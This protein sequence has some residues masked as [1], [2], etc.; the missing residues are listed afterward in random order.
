M[1]F[2]QFLCNFRSL[3]WYEESKITYL[4]LGTLMTSYLNGS[5]IRSFFQEAEEDIDAKSNCNCPG[6]PQVARTFV[7]DMTNDN[8]ELYWIDPWINKIIA[9]DMTGCKCRVIVDATEMK[10]HGFIPNSITVDSKYIYWFNSTEEEIYYTNKNQSSKI[11]HVKASYGYKIISLD[12]GNQRYPPRECLF[13]KLHNLQPKIL[14]NTDKTITLKLPSVQKADNCKRFEYEMTLTEYTILYKIKKSNDTAICDKES[15]FFVATT[16]VEVVLNDLKPF[17]NYTVMLEVTN[18]Y[19]KLHEIK[20]L[21][22]L[23]LVFQTAAEGKFYYSIIVNYLIL[24]N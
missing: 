15:C 9:T 4:G 1:F 3:F 22:G 18:Y 21:N 8:Y 6:N 17:T 19:A 13:P 5:N 14:S 23:S 2:T 11:E 20:P 12:P 10:K 24:C 7:I 16:N